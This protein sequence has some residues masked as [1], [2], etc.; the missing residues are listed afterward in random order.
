MKKLFIFAA[1]AL[2]SLASFASPARAEETKGV[3][4]AFENAKQYL[5]ELVTAKDENK[6]DDLT[7]RVETFRKVLDLST[8]EVKDFEFKL[9]TV[10]KDE[11][12]EP[13]KEEAMK[14]LTGAKVFIDSQKELLTDP[15]SLDFSEVKAIAENFKAWREK[16]YLPLVSQAQNFLLVKQEAKAVGTA[17]ARLGKITTD[18][19]NIKQSKVTNSSE[20]KKLLDGSKNLIEEAADLNREAADRF[21]E[22]NVKTAKNASSTEEETA[23]STLPAKTLATSTATSSPADVSAE[24]APIVSIKDLVGSS[25]GKIKE[26]YQGFVDI[27]NLVRKLLK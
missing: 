24:A 18:L 10:D 23:T 15:K 17:Q 26:A 11:A 27:S 9:L 20:I 2:V 1:V 25:L 6:S 12:F 3:Q 13:W 4:K 8:A 14:S 21:I 7:L 16:E 19:K 22:T 5:D